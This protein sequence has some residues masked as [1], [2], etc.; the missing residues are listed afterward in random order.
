MQLCIYVL[1]S[2]HLSLYKDDILIQT[3]A[4]CKSLPA[5]CLSIT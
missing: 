2:M 1:L 3:Q 5:V 4:D